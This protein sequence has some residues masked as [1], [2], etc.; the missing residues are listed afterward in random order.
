MNKLLEE[1]SGRFS[2]F[3]VTLEKW[4]A[5][6]SLRRARVMWVGIDQ[7]GEEKDNHDKRRSG[8]KNS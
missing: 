3:P 4:G 7:R 5:F 8:G 1:V 6:P 2:V